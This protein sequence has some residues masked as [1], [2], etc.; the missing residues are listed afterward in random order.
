MPT[1]IQI[2]RSAASDW[3]TANPVLADGEIG[4]ENDTGRLKIGD[5]ATPWRGLRYSVEK[6]FSAA[7]KSKL[8]AIQPEATSAGA[9]GDLHAG[10]TDNPHATTAAQIGAEP[11]GTVAAHAL[12][13]NAHSVGNITGLQAA[14]DSKLS[15]LSL[16]KDGD[17]PRQIRGINL[18]G[19]ASIT[20][21][22]GGVAT[23][24]FSEAAVEPQELVN[25]GAVTSSICLVDGTATS[26]SLPSPNTGVKYTTI[27]NRCAASVNVVGSVSPLSYVQGVQLDT[28]SLTASRVIASRAYSGIANG[29][30]LM[31]SVIVKPDVQNSRNTVL[32]SNNAGLG[33]NGVDVTLFA[34]AANEKSKSLDIRAS[35]GAAATIVDVRYNISQGTTQHWLISVDLSVPR[36]QFAIN[37]VLQTPYYNVFPSAG[38]EAFAWDSNTGK[39]FYVGGH[40]SNDRFPWRGIM[41]QLYLNVASALDLNVASNIGKFFDGA[42]PADL[43]LNGSLPT[44]TAPEVFLNDTDDAFFTSPKA[45]GPFSIDPEALAGNWIGAPAADAFAWAE[46]INGYPS[47]YTLTSGDPASF[48][49]M[50]NG[51]W[52]VI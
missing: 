44:G 15:T 27:K 40:G 5:A 16:Q 50:S 26:V 39:T 28:S 52:E 19:A 31:L 30:Y 12:S 43:G 38:S 34:N 13:A 41:A 49:R 35:N 11:G 17:T 18:A 6:A 36:V 23:L 46:A 25:S 3:E 20:S 37:G 2:R 8:D 42:R 45:G 48:V 24:A 9:I 7:D 22:A 47:G 29:K 32:F 21:V 1:R 4:L 33:A 14:L 10:R 51:R